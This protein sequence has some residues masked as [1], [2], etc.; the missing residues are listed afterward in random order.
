MIFSPLLVLICA[1]DSSRC[2]CGLEIQTHSHQLPCEVGHEPMAHSPSYQLASHSALQPSSAPR[3][4]HHS[5]LSFVLPAAKPPSR[6]LTNH[7]S[8]APVFSSL[9]SGIDAIVARSETSTAETQSAA[10]GVKASAFFARKGRTGLLEI[11]QQR[12]GPAVLMGSA[13]HRPLTLL[14]WS[15]SAGNYTRL[16]QVPVG[17]L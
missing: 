5:Q 11:T 3:S 17:Q 13:S 9:L 8:T 14:P 16:G 2:G 1:T 6:E 10:A 7:D 4:A 12:K 15:H